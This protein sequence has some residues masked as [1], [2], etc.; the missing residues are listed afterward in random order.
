MGEDITGPVQVTQ[1]AVTAG[2]RVRWRA[3]AGRT[4]NHLTHVPSITGRHQPRI[5]ASTRHH[6]MLPTIPALPLAGSKAR[7]PGGDRVQVPGQ[8]GEAPPG[9]R[10]G[11]LS[12]QHKT[13][14][15]R[16][17]EAS[18]TRSTRTE[19]HSAIHVGTAAKLAL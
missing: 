6:P 10:T 15:R 8:P 19:R 18:N 9:G 11:G 14:T 12:S 7:G 16:F 5:T 13:N 17:R 3:D 2:H 4:G 1:Q